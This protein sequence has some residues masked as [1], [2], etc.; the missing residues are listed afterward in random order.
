[1]ALE[2]GGPKAWA[3]WGLCGAAFVFAYFQRVA[4]SVMVGDLMPGPGKGCT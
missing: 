2:R 4:P 1:M 3:M